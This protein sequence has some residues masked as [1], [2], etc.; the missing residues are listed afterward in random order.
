MLLIDN[1]NIKL[2]DDLKSEIKEGSKLSI[3][4]ASFSIYAY[5]ELKKELENIDELRF[6]FNSP[7]FTKES[8]KKKKREF[9]IPRH[10]REQNL[11]GSNFEVKLKNE[12]TQKAIAKECA[13]WIRSKVKFKSYILND[14]KPGYMIVDDAT[15]SPVTDFTTKDLG[16]DVNNIDAYNIIKSDG[17]FTL[18]FIEKFNHIW[19]NKEIV[20]D[21]TET[22][23]E[24]IST[25]YTENTPD[26]LYFVTIY[27]IFKE[28]V[29]NL[30]EDN[31][32]NE[33]INL[34]DTVIW[35]KL[36]NF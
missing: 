8:A 24:S 12:L 20:E 26:Y 18:N 29:E 32:I 11:F 31:I 34:K 21:V 5:A 15:Y 27:N 2:A 10:T 7:T 6:I 1:N 33:K 23:I 14:N 16:V 17:P 3:F 30:S 9:Y 36:Y 35:N 22:I 4:A 19:D 28:F 25:V 13:D